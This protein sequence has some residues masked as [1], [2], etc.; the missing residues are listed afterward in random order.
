MRWSA[1]VVLLVACAP[2]STP[3]GPRPMPRPTAVPIA[4]VARPVADG[5]G[6]PGYEKRLTA[7]EA[8]VPRLASEL[9]SVERTCRDLWPTSEAACSRADAWA[10]IAHDYQGFYAEHEDAARDRGRIDALP[11]LGGRDRTEAEVV[12]NIVFVC[13]ERCDRARRE[14]RAEEVEASA[15]RCASGDRKACPALGAHEGSA[16]AS[17]RCET[18]CDDMKASAKEARE[19]EARRPRTK[20]QS[21]ACL[22]RCMRHCTGGRVVVRADGTYS[23]DPD[24]WC[25]TCDVSCAAD[26]AVVGP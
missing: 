16:G 11:R 20:A 12:A 10:A 4:E 14:G 15:K 25:G 19:R 9:E 21:I 7:A 1:V 23:K 6:P 13:T 22:Q 24:D 26:C 3:A 2:A 17:A 18:L 8:A 5:P